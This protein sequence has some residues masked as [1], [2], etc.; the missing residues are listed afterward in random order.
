MSTDVGGE[1]N[2]DAAYH[3]W[4]QRIAAEHA[5]DVL[6]V[7]C[8]DGLLAQRLAEVSRSVIGIDKDPV[9]IAQAHKR[10]CMVP[11]TDA[12]VSEFGTE[13]GLVPGSYDVVTMVSA[14]HELPLVP[15]LE[16]VVDLLKP[17]GTLVV[18][19]VTAPATVVD[20]AVEWA[21][22]PYSR[23]LE[24]FY[25]WR[26]MYRPEFA[27]AQPAKPAYSFADVADAAAELLPGAE[28]HRGLLGRYRL[29]W[30]KPVT[31]A[32]PEAELGAMA[33]AA[34]QDRP[35]GESLDEQDAHVLA[36][37]D[38][39]ELSHLFDQTREVPTIEPGPVRRSA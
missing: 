8:G 2:R 12:A 1:W 15:T 21:S 37:D 23:A 28:L 25:T 16:R 13:W 20:R 26:G 29:R 18:V 32:A 39:D 10:L 17:G 34:I 27:S 38:V 4:I 5:G 36:R 33:A 31:V 11:N 35:D 22:V 6:D 24:L 3:P 14:L 7:G 30:A 9:A 19:G